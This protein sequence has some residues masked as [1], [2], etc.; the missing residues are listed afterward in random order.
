VTQGGLLRS[1]NLALRRA[2][3]ADLASLVALQRAA[4]AKNR[5]LLGVE[6]IPLLADYG[7]ILR[8]MEVWVAE[9]DTRLVGALILEPRTD[10]L[11]IWSIAA[12]PTTQ[13]AGLGR[14]LLAAAEERARQLG[15]TVVRLYTGTPL[16]HLV[17]WY[18][19][20]GYAVERIEA[21]SDRSIAHMIKHLGSEHGKKDHAGKEQRA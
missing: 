17:A 7:A 21:L 3:T 12:D 18:G 9:N 1:G 20:H 15:R 8:D 19:R 5:P 10:D 13:G 2:E 14:T 6:P 4:Y 16:S 11:L